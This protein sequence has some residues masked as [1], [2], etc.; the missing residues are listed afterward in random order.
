MSKDYLTA[1]SE[2]LGLLMPIKFKL[3]GKYTMTCHPNFD[4]IICTEAYRK[5]LGKMLPATY[6]EDIAHK[7]EVRSESATKQQPAQKY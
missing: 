7:S 3:F 2:F 5:S 1:H 4:I 6:F